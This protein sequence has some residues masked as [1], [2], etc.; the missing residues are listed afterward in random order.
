MLLRIDNPFDTI[1]DTTIGDLIFAIREAAVEAKET[2][3]LA[4]E[5]A[6]LAVSFVLSNCEVTA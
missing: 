3:L 6:V 5:A 4:L 2:A 1:I